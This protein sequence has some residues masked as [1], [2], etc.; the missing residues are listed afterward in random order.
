[1]HTKAVIFDM[2]G[3][4]IDSEAYYLF[5]YQFLMEKHNQHITRDQLLETAGMAMDEFWQWMVDHWSTPMTIEEM[6][7]L[8]YQEPM[9]QLDYEDLKMPHLRLVLQE[10]K[11]E[12]FKL[13]IASSSYMDLIEEMMQQLHIK[14]YFD[15]VCSGA[16]FKESKPNPEIYIETMARLNVHPNHAYVIEDS[17][18]GIEA[19]KAS[20]AYVIA[21][22]DKRFKMD[23]S[24]ADYIASDLLDALLK[25][26]EMEKQK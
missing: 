1:M 4:M 23:Q 24:E 3:V 26:I 19:G 11:K 14:D 9:A 16:D 13:A 12:G 6:Q 22:E 2:D 15:V 18:Y 20:Q 21:K 10:L 7:K 5:A 17:I 25:I 8:I